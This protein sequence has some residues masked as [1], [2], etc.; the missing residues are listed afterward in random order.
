M[1]L[2]ELQDLLENNLFKLVPSTDLKRPFFNPYYDKDLSIDLPDADLLRRQNLLNYLH[3]F[4]ERPELL[5]IG[6]APGWRG[7]R[8]SG[9]PFTSEAQLC[10][11]NLPICGV[12]SSCCESP[13]SEATAFTF[14]KVMAP[15]HPHFLAWNCF[16]FHP[17]LPGEQ[18]SNR[19]PTRNEIRR[20]KHI[21]YEM[22]RLLSPQKVIAVGK[23]A[24][25][26]LTQ[27]GLKPIVVR[28]PAHGGARRF[29]EKMEYIF[30][31]HGAS[32]P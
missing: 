17:H 23:S 29:I 1:P 4:S 16:P 11:G 26:A 2:R 25:I 20:F 8:F 13:F 31:E 21:L 10:N 32:S 12:R 5:V 3:S 22:V 19:R 27:I 28:H 6:E 15:K 30:I 14:W 9:I 24:E 18:L 7:C